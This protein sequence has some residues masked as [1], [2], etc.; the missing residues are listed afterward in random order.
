MALW[1]HA[2]ERELKVTLEGTGVRASALLLRGG[3]TPATHELYE[4]RRR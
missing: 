4:R 3:R 1:R 2:G